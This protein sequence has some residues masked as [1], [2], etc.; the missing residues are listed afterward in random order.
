MSK[1]TEKFDEAVQ[2][3]HEQAFL[4]YS[5]QVKSLD[6]KV[7]KMVNEAIEKISRA[8]EKTHRQAFDK[9]SDHIKGQQAAFLKVDEVVKKAVEKVNEAAAKAHDQAFTRFSE[10]IREKES[11]TQIVNEGF[12]K[13]LNEG[14]TKISQQLRELQLSNTAQQGAVNATTRADTAIQIRLNSPEESE[15]GSIGSEEIEFV[16]TRQLVR[17][18][19]IDDGDGALRSIADLSSAIWDFPSPGSTYAI[20]MNDNHK[21]MKG[22]NKYSRKFNWCPVTT[23][24]LDSGNHHFHWKCVGEPNDYLHFRNRGYNYY[25]GIDPR[26]FDKKSYMDPGFSKIGE[27]TRIYLLSADEKKSY[28]LKIRV[29]ERSFYLTAAFQPTVHNNNFMRLECKEE[30]DD[31]IT[32]WLFRKMPEVR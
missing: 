31:S 24:N 30:L 20:H 21:Y 10:Q 4:N 11:S 12:Q 14:F 32:R 17:R 22:I 16:S 8:V 6:Q 5:E 18:D 29:G 15:H 7:D 13:A 23:K 25:M 27:N 2:K 19:G 9:F 28:L 1:A 3:A 26:Q